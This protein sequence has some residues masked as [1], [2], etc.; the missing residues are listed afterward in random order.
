MRQNP[1]E[2]LMA[3]TR[4]FR[5]MGTEAY[6]EIIHK[7]SETQKAKSSITR[8]IE[9]CFEKIPIFNRFDPESELSQFNQHLGTF[10]N[11]SPDMLTVALHALS[12]HKESDGLFE[13]RILPI[14]EDIGY[15]S[16]FSLRDIPPPAPSKLLPI[17]ASS[18]RR[19]LKVWGEM[20]RFDVPM[21]FSGIAKGY[22]L[23]KMAERIASDGWS[24]FLVDSGGDMVIRGT[25]R[26]KSPWRIDI[27]NIPDSAILLEISE[28]GVATS[29]ITR[30]QWT[31]SEG[32]RYHHLIHPKHPYSFSFDILSVTAISI[33]AERADFLAKTLFLMGIKEGFACAEKYS[34]PAV[35]VAES[36][37]KK[38]NTW[39][40]TSEAKKYLAKK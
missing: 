27:E 16:D 11:A 25:N 28:K 36:K 18:L 24:N 37:N 15:R 30:R 35:F 21:D 2:G 17:Y 23:D 13:P 4:L 10:R 33:S 9:L 29:G 6:I 34:I 7:K 3:T 1:K 40:I 14:L 12:Y 26:E 5:A 19:D 22:I 8:A 20:I 31:S 32:T 38:M 39:H